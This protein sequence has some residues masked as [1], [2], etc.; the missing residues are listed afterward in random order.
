MKI[1]I[2]AR[3]LGPMSKGLGRYAERLVENLEKKDKKNE[4]VVF[5]RK[6]NWDYYTPKFSNFKKVLADYR[7]YSL[8]EQIMMPIAI[9]KEKID[10][11]H[12]PHFNIPI[13]SP[14]KFVTTIHDLILLRFPTPRA[15]KVQCRRN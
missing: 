6:E 13:F 3:F 12:F 14:T 8:K 11:M 1:G 2:D 15:T 9:W 5:L 10:L 4:Y 7:W